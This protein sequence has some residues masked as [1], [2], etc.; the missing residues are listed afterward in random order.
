MSV[1]TS[2]VRIVIGL[3]I[4]SMIGI[5]FGIMIGFY[6]NLRN[7]TN[8]P[9]QFIRM[10]SPL[11]WMPIALILL[12]GFEYAIYFLITISS[13]WPIIL[14]TSQGV[15]SVDKEWI[16]MAL[17]QGAKEYQLLFKVIFRASIPYILSGLR[18]AVGVAWIILVPAEFLGV[19]S[20]LGYLIND[21]RDTLRYDNL[22]AIVIAI[23][24]IGFLIDAV[25][26]ILLKIFDWRKG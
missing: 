21:A 16:R 10:I 13:I 6:K 14:S 18:L 24:V 1:L 26:Q 7:I 12:P 23:G 19:S 11:S 22:M 5:P 3:L 17:N 9:I 8:A 2:I 15:T 25:F 4:A 20:G